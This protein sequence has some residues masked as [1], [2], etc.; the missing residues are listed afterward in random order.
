MIHMIVYCM[1]QYHLRIH[2][3]AEHEL[4]K[5]PSDT[6]TKLKDILRS[7]SKQEVPARHG[8]VTDLVGID[9]CYRV[10]CNGFRAIIQLDKPNLLVLKVTKRDGAYNRLE[11]TI[12]NRAV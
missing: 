5:A 4:D 2:P 7:V 10:R 12:E 1:A 6:K 9:D 11:Q 8:S 3:R